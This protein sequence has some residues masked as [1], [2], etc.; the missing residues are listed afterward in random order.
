MRG[1]GLPRERLTYYNLV[2]MKTLKYQKYLIVIFF[3]LFVMI[4]GFC[5]TVKAS[6]QPRCHKCKEKDLDLVKKHKILGYDGCFTCHQD[7][8]E[9]DLPKKKAN[10][11]N[12]R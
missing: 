8:I 1:Q 11:R 7:L 10:R 2:A 6:K 9:K 3:S 5:S 4:G 12:R